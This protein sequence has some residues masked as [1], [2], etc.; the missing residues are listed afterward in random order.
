MTSD[1]VSQ[2]A[3]WHA[4][5][6][7]AGYSEADY[8]AWLP[9]ELPLSAKLAVP[10]L[11]MPA[12]AQPR[13]SFLI[14]APAVTPALETTL[15]SACWDSRSIEIVLALPADVT[16]EGAAYGNVRRVAL[17]A[18]ESA[19]AN[20]ALAA[21]AG[22]FVAFLSPGDV[23]RA[24][25]CAFI[26]GRLLAAPTLNMAYASE[27]W[28][29]A[30]GRRC[31]PRFKPEWDPFAQLAFDL[32]GRLC[33][34]RREQ[35]TALGGLRPA[36]APA[37]H[38]DL[39]LRLGTHVPESTIA[40]WPE[41]V[42]HRAIPAQSDAATVEHCVA[43]YADAAQRA[44]SAHLG[45]PVT[46][47][48]LATF[49]NRPHFARPEEALRVTILVPT[50]D[51]VELLQ[52]CLSG[53]LQRTDYPALD[54][55]IL[56]NESR[57]PATLAYFAELAADP[58]VEVLRVPGPFNYSAINNTGVRAARGD[59]LVFMN[60]DVEVITPG[61]LAEMVAVVCRPEVGCV[62]AKL[63][64]GDGRVQH[65][66]V[67]LEPGPLAMHVHRLRGSEELGSNA[68][69]AGL[70]RCSAVTAACLAVRRDVFDE[71]GG[72]DEHKLRIAYND[73]DLCLK[74][75]DS[76]RSNVCVA[77]E[78]LFHLEGASRHTQADPVKIAQDRREMN[79]FRNRWRERFDADPVAH[80]NIRRDWDLPDRLVAFKAF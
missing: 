8:A 54:I 16:F 49:I 27:D 33:I 69:L 71:V 18:E 25:A 75:E 41:I 1:E 34:M 76:G 70:A 67:S 58:R 11:D 30:D 64:Y 15:R 32:P 12:A 24:G 3:L 7:M 21:A 78:P 52:N 72:F 31:L 6:L 43:R 45:R 20:A 77:Y 29:D 44:A 37:D 38:Y 80:P 66:G 57:E 42:C 35:V 51:R 26:I 56:D 39:H 40:R 61:W 68:E 74:V 63:L 2:T 79:A 10:L 73:I 13:L 48:P 65:A 19:T 23:L 59:I 46:A 5:T 4:A 55:L 36:F 17:P 50:R 22:E 9:R 60:N 14:A 47:S 62:G 28:I 53:L